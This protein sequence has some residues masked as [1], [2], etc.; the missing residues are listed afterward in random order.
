MIKQKRME[1]LNVIN[2]MEKSIC[3]PCGIIDTAT[4]NKCTIGFEFKKF[5]DRMLEISNIKNEKILSKG[6]DMTTKDIERLLDKDV[7]RS[8]ISKALGQ[9][10]SKISESEER[11]DHSK[12]L[13][14]AKEN[15]IPERSYYHSVHQ[16]GMTQTEAATTPHESKPK[17]IKYPSW[18]YENMKENGINVSQFHARIYH[19]WSVKRACTEPIK[20][21]GRR[22]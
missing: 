8:R 18:V 13:K 10:A 19:G 12:Y 15:G 3:K 11:L 16:L 21:R 22:S 4:C 5:D 17:G 14:M 6:I 7:T 2:H 20:G 9:D 1:V